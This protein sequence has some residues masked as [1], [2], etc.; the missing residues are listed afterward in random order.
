[1]L[2][3]VFVLIVFFS[4]FFRLLLVTIRVMLPQGFDRNVD[5]GVKNVVIDSHFTTPTSV[6]DYSALMM[7]CELWRSFRTKFVLIFQSD[8]RFCSNSRFTVQQFLK[9]DYAWIGAPWPYVRTRT[10]EQ[11]NF[12]YFF[13]F[14][15]IISFFF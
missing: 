14:I 8:S 7:N 1:M 2:A 13:K 3:N 10:N 4:V 6:N 9:M 12:V 11:R 5:F 15:V